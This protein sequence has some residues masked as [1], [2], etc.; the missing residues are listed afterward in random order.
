LSKAVS[1]VRG[2]AKSMRQFYKQEEKARKLAKR[3]EQREQQPEP[4]EA[5]PGQGSERRP[6]GAR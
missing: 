5:R 1:G 6:A 3:R 2:A 4:G